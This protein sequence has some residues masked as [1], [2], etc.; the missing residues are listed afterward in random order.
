MEWIEPVNV[1]SAVKYTSSLVD[2]VDQERQ[3]IIHGSITGK[4]FSC[5]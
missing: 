2:A 5:P 1:K 4:V 3:N